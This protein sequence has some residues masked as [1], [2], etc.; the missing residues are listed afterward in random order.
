MSKRNTICGAN[1][2]NCPQI[3][4]CPGCKETN[5][6]PF[7]GRCVAAEC[8]KCSGME[9]YQA[10]KQDLCDELNALSIPSLPQITE[11]NELPGFYVNLSYP[12]ENGTIVKLLDDKRIYLGN[13]LPFGDGTQGRCFGVLADDNMLIV[14][15]YGDMS[16]ESELICYRKRTQ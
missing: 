4:T 11:L 8:I 13:Q 7:G 1:C 15:S 12:L 5:G 10:L 3:A 16:D 6:Q 14:C 2:D 9:A